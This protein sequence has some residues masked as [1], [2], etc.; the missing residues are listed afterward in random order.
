MNVAIF[1]LF[2]MLQ[3]PL[4]HNL[5]IALIYIQKNDDFHLTF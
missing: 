3:I 1:F 4:D 2:V 5:I